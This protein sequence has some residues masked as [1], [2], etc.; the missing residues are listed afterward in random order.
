MP[1]TRQGEL[2]CV[3]VYTV[4]IHRATM[5]DAVHTQTLPLK[6][7]YQATTGTSTQQHQPLLHRASQ[8]TCHHASLAACNTL[9]LPPPKQGAQHARTKRTM[10]MTTRHAA[11]II[12]ATW[13]HPRA[14]RSPSTA[15][16]GRAVAIHAAHRGTGS[17]RTGSGALG[18]LVGCRSK[19]KRAMIRAQHWQAPI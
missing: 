13:S 12:S 11:S 1:A 10:T 16:A 5:E 2:P 15:K 6:D 3:H 9:W 17:R 4:Q 18:R 14:H 7:Q 8:P 19:G